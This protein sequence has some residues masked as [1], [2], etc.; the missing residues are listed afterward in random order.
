MNEKKFFVIMICM[1]QL[2]PV[3]E[4][5]RRKRKVSK[6]LSLLFVSRVLMRVSLGAIG[7]FLPIFFYEQLAPVFGSKVAIQQVILI[8]VSIYS[9]NLLLSPIAASLFHRWGMRRMMSTGIFMAAAAI[10]ALF[11]FDKNI[12]LGMALYIL[13]TGLY[14]A[15][16]WVPYHVDLAHELDMQRRGKQLAFMANMSDA[17]VVF[18]PLLGGAAIAF[19]GG[20]KEVYIMAAFL[21]L[22]AMIP[23]MFM[24]DIYEYY[25]WS[26]FDTFKKLFS[27]ENTHLFIAQAANGAQSVA[28]LFFWPLYVYFISQKQFV[29]LGAVT[30]ATIIFIMFLRWFIGKLIDRYERKKMLLAGILLS[31]TGWFLKIFVYTPIQ[32]VFV[33]TYHRMGRTANSLVFSAVTYEQ[34]ADSGTYIDEYTTLK[35]MAVNVGRIAMLLAVG[36]IMLYFHTNIRAAFLVAAVVTLFMILLDSFNRLR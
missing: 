2:D 6:D 27:R 16:Y 3:I 24:N 30:S 18:V 31:A 12:F 32:A 14:R 20:F 33:D 35:E 7:V 15:L 36:V 13:T 23:L 19:F 25:S 8:F 28:T 9:L 29:I 34:S 11:Y 22:L 10:I 26:Y 21:M 5:V 17:L 1:M 4:A